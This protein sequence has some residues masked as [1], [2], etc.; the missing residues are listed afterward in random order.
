MIHVL[1]KSIPFQAAPAFIPEPPPPLDWE[2]GAFHAHAQTAPGSSSPAAPAFPEPVR[3]REIK[4]D[5]T[6]GK[7]NTAELWEGTKQMGNIQRT[8]VR[9]S[10]DLEFFK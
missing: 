2:T 7:Q 10:G 9:I 3:N 4:A 1:I 8:S 6:K 5:S